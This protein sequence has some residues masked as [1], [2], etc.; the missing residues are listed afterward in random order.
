MVRY[1]DP[2]VLSDDPCRVAELVHEHRMVDSAD[3]LARASP[4]VLHVRE[5]VQEVLVR[6]QIQLH[7]D[8][9]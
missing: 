5:D 1:D 7:A 2:A 9:S 8:A 4:E 3:A 6:A